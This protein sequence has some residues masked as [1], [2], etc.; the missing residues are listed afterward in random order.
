MESVVMDKY[1]RAVL[2][3][4]HESER[5]KLFIGTNKTFLTSKAPLTNPPTPHVDWKVIEGVRTEDGG[6]H[7]Y[8]LS[9]YTL[10]VVAWQTGAQ[11]VIECTFDTKEQAEAAVPNCIE[12]CKIKA[13]NIS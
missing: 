11:T 13:S 12:L 3:F 7:K 6:I 9:G 5:T 8:A 1:A 2:G 4:K 10:I